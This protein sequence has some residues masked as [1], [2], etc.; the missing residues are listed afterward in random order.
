MS[1]GVQ[2][3]G[4]FKTRD[5]VILQQKFYGRQFF[6]LDPD[7]MVKFDK[8]GGH[9]DPTKC[10]RVVGNAARWTMEILLDKGVVEV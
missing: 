1:G 9:S 3:S 6:F 10:I 7:E 2:I 8:A 5:P 4:P